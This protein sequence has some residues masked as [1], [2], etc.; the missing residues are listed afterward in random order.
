MPGLADGGNGEGFPGLVVRGELLQIQPTFDGVIPCPMIR[1]GPCAKVSWPSPLAIFSV[2]FRVLGMADI[3][4]RRLRSLLADHFS[5]KYILKNIECEFEDAEV[6]YRPDETFQGGE[7]RK[8]VAGYYNGLDFTDVVDARKFLN[9]CASVLKEIDRQQENALRSTPSWI[10]SIPKPE[11]EHPLDRLILELHRCGYEWREGAIVN[12]SS[13]ARLADTK[14]YA[15]RFDLNHLTE[16]TQRI[17]KAIDADPPQAIGS[18]KE[19]I[20]TVAKT[21]LTKR[22]V[23]YAR[24]ND[25]LELGKAVFK[26]LKQVPDGVPEAAKGAAIIKRTLSNLASLVQG[27]AELRGFYGTGHGQ[28]G[29]FK[30]LRARHAKLAVGAAATLATYWI[31]TDREMS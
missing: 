25:I 12:A 22:N 26:T 11:S 1:L 9:V 7:R 17:E 24:G 3:I 10:K 28:E 23:P 5:E 21:I 13:S 29:D 30:G 20:E 4:S 2:R 8:L 27:I 19:L 6:P 14:A 31:E 15:D 18:A 16:H